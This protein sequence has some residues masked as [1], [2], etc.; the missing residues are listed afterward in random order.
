MEDD[1][2]L[3]HELLAIGRISTSK[4][5]PEAG[6][7]EVPMQLE[8]IPSNVLE[9]LAR[10]YRTSPQ[11]AYILQLL[12]DTGR[13][14]TEENLRFIEN[15]YGDISTIEMTSIQKEAMWDKFLLSVFSTYV[16][17]AIELL[18]LEDNRLGDGPKAAL[19]F[20]NKSKEIIEGFIQPI[21]TEWRAYHP[22]ATT[23]DTT[24]F[25]I[26]M[27]TGLAPGDA[28]RLFIVERQRARE[29]AEM[30][31]NG[32]RTGKSEEEVETIN[33][34]YDLI[35]ELEKPVSIISELSISHILFE[36]FREN[37]RLTDIL[38]PVRNGITVSS[39]VVRIKKMGDKLVRMK[40]IP[41]PKEVHEVVVKEPMKA[42]DALTE[43]A[44]DRTKRTTIVSDSNTFAKVVEGELEKDLE[45]ALKKLEE[46]ALGETGSEEKKTEDE[47]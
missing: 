13:A 28:S 1:D 32:L 19:E 14:D 12:E 42:I 4:A 37:R 6:L 25:F 24:V 16:K 15:L 17:K 23:A 43:G 41:A 31:M 34:N 33:D 36:A 35:F 3:K 21:V 18:G 2:S 11:K 26:T 47:H 40:G 20:Q 44:Y 22:L 45:K 38:M 30:I 5:K 9:E 39:P 10:R 46:L 8:P 29:R 27:I 7:E